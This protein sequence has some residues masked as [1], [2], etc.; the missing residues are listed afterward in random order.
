M[1]QRLGASEAEIERMDDES[2]AVI[3]SGSAVSA[4]GSTKDREKLG[5]AKKAKTNQSESESDDVDRS[6][7]DDSDDDDN[8]GDDGDDGDAQ[9]T[10]FV[11]SNKRP[12]GNESKG[13]ATKKP[14]KGN[15]VMVVEDGDAAAPDVVEDL[16]A[17]SDDEEW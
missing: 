4:P 6:A 7:D 16:G 11:S 2:T 13:V 12:R 14:A 15:A 8:D 9:N 10:R 5:S 1:R 17:W 3:G